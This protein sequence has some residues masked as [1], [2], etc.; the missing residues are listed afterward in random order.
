VRRTGEHRF[1]VR[2]ATVDWLLDNTSVLARSFRIVPEVREGRP[3][4][5]HLFGVRADGPFG[6]LGLRD[7]DLI[8]AI[9][10]LEMT[11]P[12][13]ALDVYLKLRAAGHLSVGLERA[14]RR[15]TIDYDIR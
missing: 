13:N 3:A 5:F 15:V 4:G 1:E 10:G 11:R 7:G 8:S 9:N 2:R 12:E 6:V 14:G